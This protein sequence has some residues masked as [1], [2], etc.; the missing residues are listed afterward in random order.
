MIHF[1]Y[2][3]VRIAIPQALVDEGHLG[4][5]YYASRLVARAWHPQLGDGSHQKMSGV[6]SDDW[7][8]CSRSGE[9]LMGYPKRFRTLDL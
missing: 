9:W 4:H 8:T 6:A 5:V 2:R 7:R 3:L 1:N